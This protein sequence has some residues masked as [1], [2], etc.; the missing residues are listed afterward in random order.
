M[1]VSRSRC[2][3]IRLLSSRV[4]IVVAQYTTEYRKVLQTI[5]RD[6]TEQ[7]LSDKFSVDEIKKLIT[8][9]FSNRYNILL[10]E[11]YEPSSYRHREVLVR[12]TFPRERNTTHRD[13]ITLIENLTLQLVDRN[14]ARYN[15]ELSPK[16]HNSKQRLIIGNKRTYRM[17]SILS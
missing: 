15:F 7:F 11:M 1:K 12:C 8:L 5:E 10:I 2:S 13:S 17:Y 16:T 9:C 6:D 3:S 4:G 14:N